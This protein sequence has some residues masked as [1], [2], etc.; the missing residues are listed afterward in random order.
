[1]FT[2]IRPVKC[3]IQIING[4]KSPEKG[5][6]LVIITPPQNNIIIPLWT[7]YYMPLNTQNTISQTA[8][9]KYNNFRSVRTE[10]LRWLQITTDTGM[11]LKVET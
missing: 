1:M 8:L 11:R 6:D 7:S 4:S 2:Y 9:K 3:N 5:F 10:A